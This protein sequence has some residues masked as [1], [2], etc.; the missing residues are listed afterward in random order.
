MEPL[1]YS[2]HTNKLTSVQK[3]CWLRDRTLN[4]RLEAELGTVVH[5]LTFERV[6]RMVEHMR[7]PRCDRRHS[8][9]LSC[10]HSAF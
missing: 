4:E 8:E 7:H 3:I 5:H 9:F 2:K 10:A 1:I 6:E